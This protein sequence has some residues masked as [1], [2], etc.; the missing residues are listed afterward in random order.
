VASYCQRSAPPCSAQRARWAGPGHKCHESALQSDSMH[1]G[2]CIH[3]IQLRFAEPWRLPACLPQKPRSSPLTGEIGRHL[4]LPLARLA[5]YMGNAPRRIR[6]CKGVDN[7]LTAKRLPQAVTSCSDVHVLQARCTKEASELAACLLAGKSMNRWQQSPVRAGLEKQ[8]SKG[9]QCS[10]P[11]HRHACSHSCLHHRLKALQA[12][13]HGAVD[14]PH[15]ESIGC[16]R[17]DCHA[18]CAGFYC[19]LKALQTVPNYQPGLNATSE[20]CEWR[21]ATS[22]SV[23]CKL[24]ALRAGKVRQHGPQ[25][26][27]CCTPQD[28][29]W[30]WAGT[31]RGTRALVAEKPCLHVG[32][33]HTVLYSG[34]A[35]YLLHHFCSIRKLR[36]PL[37]RHETGDF[38]ALQPARAQLVHHANLDWG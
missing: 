36:Y 27:H 15:G 13:L 18:V 20:S 38:D 28:C 17:E 2:D 33:E 11:A 14:V 12:L 9:P 35:L 21:H 16:G 34:F 32:C 4:R 22:P 24:K 7:V 25:L 3:G 29:R 30:H 19:T 1:H 31:A 5:R 37:W 6:I 23:H 26:K 10:T 8:V